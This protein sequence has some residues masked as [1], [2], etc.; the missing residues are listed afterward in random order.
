MTEPFRL[1]ERNTLIAPLG[2]RF[3]DVATG[4]YISNG[5]R[6]AAYPDDDQLHL[7]HASANRS[8]TYVL[9]HASGLRE[10][11]LGVGN[12]PFTDVLPARR[13]FTI[14]V[15][16]EERRFLPL[17]LEAD[18]PFKGLFR[19]E[20][21]MPGGVPSDLAVSPHV[22]LFSSILRTDPAGMAV[23]RV[24]LYESPTVEVNGVRI[25][26]PAAWSM[27]EAR[28]NG[29]LVGRGIADDKGRIAV[30]FAYPAPHD[31][32]SSFGSSPAGSFT[33]G[34]PFLKEQ[35]TIDLQAY[36][37]P[38]VVSSPLSPLSPPR[39]TRAM[40]VII[41]NLRDILDQSSAS[42]F[43][44]DERTRPLTEVTLMYGPK[45]LI[46]PFGSPLS[47]PVNPVSLS[48]LFVSPAGSPP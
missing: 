41:P 1:I 44:D 33:A 17:K 5:L 12:L 23:L 8:G 30:I 4:A 42:L 7:T 24:E 11:E 29:R 32:I 35:W 38:N 46:P 28:Y 16:D 15:K 19:W 2:I 14:T 39:P 27:V 43:L 48:T 10:F 31:S 22:P 3:W 40:D 37:E 26:K 25:K 36:Y 6:V 34:V 13:R 21:T 47:S 9:H 18:L 45:V 20:S